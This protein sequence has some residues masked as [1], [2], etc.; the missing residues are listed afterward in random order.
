MSGNIVRRVEKL[1][2]NG[3]AAPAQEEGRKWV[4]KQDLDDLY[5]CLTGEKPPS[6]PRPDSDY[7]DWLNQAWE[8]MLEDAE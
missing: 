6:P 3:Q 2:R 8:Q 5:D 1:E 4:T 7:P